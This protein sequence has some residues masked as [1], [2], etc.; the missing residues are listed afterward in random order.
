MKQLQVLCV[1]GTRPEC[2]KMAPVIRALAEEPTINALV[3]VTG[4]HRQMLDGVLKLF[5]ITPDFDLNIMQKGQHL[6]DIT[7]K[8]LC[9]L[10]G[11]IRECTPDMILVQG[12]TTTTMAASLAA[13]YQKVSVG[14]VEAGLRTGDIYSPWPEEINRKITSVIANIH[15]TPTIQ[16]RQNLLTEGIEDTYIKVTGNTVIDAL[17][18]VID[19]IKRDRGFVQRMHQLYPFLENNVGTDQVKHMILVTGHRRESF[20]TGFENICH[21][22]KDLAKRSDVNIMYPVHMNPNVRE[23]VFRIL[24]GLN[25]IKLIDPLD[26]RQFIYFMYRAKLII[27]DSGGVQEEAPSLGKPVLVL[28]DVTER[29]EAVDAGTVKLVGTN[30]RRIVEETERLLNDS[31]EYLRMSKKSNPYGDGKASGRI[32]DAILEH[33]DRRE[34]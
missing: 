33:F 21:A 23:P 31:K 7:S 17:L 29:P 8:V 14:H 19:G 26:Y 24:D 6:E 11:I 5:R 15:F 1:F 20:G 2:I 27:T 28:R 25:N 9:S 13:F 10:D 22:L 3:C 16:A 12:D 32:V 30:R 18:D 4:Q 34:P